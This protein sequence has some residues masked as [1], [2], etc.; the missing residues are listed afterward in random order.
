MIIKL[1][2]KD[3]ERF[4]KKELSRGT[5]CI[6]LRTGI[7][8]YCVHRVGGGWGRIRRDHMVGEGWGERV[9]GETPGIGSIWGV[10]WKL[11]A[12]HAV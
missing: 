4:S 6:Y 8:I 12:I 9:Q 3:P 10:V 11:L 7:R 1:Q 5:V 2:S